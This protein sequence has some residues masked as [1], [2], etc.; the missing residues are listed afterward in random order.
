[1]LP[2]NIII[3]APSEVSC[4]TVNSRDSWFRAHRASKG[5]WNDPKKY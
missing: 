4:A 2:Y 3:R 5:L 1:M